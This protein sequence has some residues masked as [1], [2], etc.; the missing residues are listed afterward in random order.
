MDAGISNNL[1]VHPLL[2]PGRNVDVINVFDTSAQCCAPT[3][4]WP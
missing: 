4:G 3:T 2:W 1:P